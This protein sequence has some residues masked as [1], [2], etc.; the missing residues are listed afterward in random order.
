MVLIWCFMFRSFFV[1]STLYSN[2]I[3]L[4][5][6]IVFNLPPPVLCFSASTFCCLRIFSAYPS[7]S[8]SFASS[9][10]LSH[11]C[12]HSSDPLIATCW[13]LEACLD[14]RSSSKKIF[15]MSSVITGIISPVTYI[16][17]WFV[18]SCTMA[19][20][21]II[22]TIISVIIFTSSP[23]PCFCFRPQYL[24]LSRLP[25]TLLE[26]SWSRSC[27]PSKLIDALV[28]SPVVLVWA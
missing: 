4:F 1:S 24:S 22:M 14:L 6:A 16:M 25:S 27:A 11:I 23:A 3:N 17:T 18:I 9:C 15:A 19:P 26:R 2:S 12:W 10:C 8:Q 21:I 20:S 28:S 5:I 13:S 7:S